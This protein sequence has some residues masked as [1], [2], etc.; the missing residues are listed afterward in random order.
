MQNNNPLQD[1]LDK[2]STV[3]PDSAVELQQDIEKNI[4]AQ[5]K[6]LLQK[7][8][9]VTKEEFNVQAKLLERYR[10]KLHELENRV[11]ELEE[12]RK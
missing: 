4:K 1:L 2:I 7:M 6:G 11:S 8:D 10:E 9:L 5:A 12:Q 3:L